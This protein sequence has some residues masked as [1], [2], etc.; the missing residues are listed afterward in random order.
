MKTTSRKPLLPTSHDTAN[1]FIYAANALFRGVVTAVGVWMAPLMGLPPM[2]PTDMLAS[3][4]GGNTLVWRPREKRWQVVSRT[5]MA[6]PG[7][8]T[9]DGKVK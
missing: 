4:M 9:L 5:C 1:G 6:F 2:N 7:S 3:A 8:L